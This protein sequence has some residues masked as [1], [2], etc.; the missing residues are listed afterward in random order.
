MKHY[1]YQADKDA[2]VEDTETARE[3][4]IMTAVQRIIEEK[5]SKPL[6]L[7][8]KRIINLLPH[9]SDVETQNVL[10]YLTMEYWQD[11]AKPALIPLASEAVGGDSASTNPIAGAITVMTIGIAIHDDIIDQSK[12][13]RD[14]LTIFGKFGINAAIIAGYVLMLEGFTMYCEW[15]NK[16]VP[17]EKLS[18]MHAIVDKGFLDLGNAEALTY[19]LKSRL[20]VS[21]QKYMRVIQKKASLYEA[22]TKVGAIIGGGTKKHIRALGKYGRMLGL[23]VTIRDEFTDLSDSYELTRRMNHDCLPLPIL[24]LLKDPLLKENILRILRKEKITHNDVHALKNLVS[25]TNDFQMLTMKMKDLADKAASTLSFLPKSKAK[26][27]TSLPY[28]FCITKL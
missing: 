10:N 18:C 19:A 24:Y 3:A 27:L 25:Q 20:D 12:T 1:L 14:R 22:Q 7:A 5:G 11:L 9:L 26:I 13:K 6:D 28:L 17:K 2:V 16:V 23:L 21:P 8:R 15:A 4:K